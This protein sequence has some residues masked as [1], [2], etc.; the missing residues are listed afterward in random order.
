MMMF[1]MPSDLSVPSALVTL[2]SV[3]LLIF[4]HV[5]ITEQ[6]RTRKFLLYL[7]ARHIEMPLLKISYHLFRGKWKRLGS[8]KIVRAI[9]SFLFARPFGYLGDSAKPVP[10]DEI[11][12]YIDET[13]GPIAVG[14]CRCR[15]AHRA[16]DHPIET[17]IVLRSGYEAWTRAFPDHYRTI[18]K[19]EAKDIVKQCH[20]LGMMHMIFIHCPVNLYNEYV[21]CN[22]C[23]CGCVPYIIN[24]ELGQLNYPLIDGYFMAVT[25]SSA[26]T[27]CGACI[28]VCP[29]DARV[30]TETVSITGDNCYGCGLCSYKC[31]EEAIS[32]IRLRDPLPHR[33]DDGSWPDG[34]RPGFYKQHEPYREE[35][36]KGGKK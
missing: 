10:Y 1:L 18:S 13:E 22:C 15:S 24:R 14:P 26:C 9:A 4:S 29:F 8:K 32:M 19:A 23:T 3:G 33:R 35:P 5:I 25:D 30:L 6:S 34:Y 2:Y 31:P 16:C 7:F 27:G 21:I 11:L 28:E 36:N 12:H 20:D 17:D